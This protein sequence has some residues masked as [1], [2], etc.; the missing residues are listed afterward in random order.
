[1]RVISILHD[2]RF[3]W[4]LTLVECDHLVQPDVAWRRVH[5]LSFVRVVYL[6]R[7]RE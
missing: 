5:H 7:R 3:L 2:C 4:S 6:L 1:M